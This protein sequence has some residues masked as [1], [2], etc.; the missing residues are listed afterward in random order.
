[1]N[2]TPKET[3]SVPE[4][5]QPELMP[6]EFDINITSYYFVYLRGNHV[7]YEDLMTMKQ[8]FDPVEKNYVIY[9]LSIRNKD[10]NTLNFSINKL[11]L[12]AG[13]QVFAPANPGTTLRY[14]EDFTYVLSEMEKENRLNDTLL[15]PHQN[16]EGI[17]IFQVDNSTTLFDRSFS[18]KYNTTPIPS[19]SYEKSLEALTAAEQFNYSIAFDMPPYDNYLGGDYSFYPEPESNSVWAN[20]VNIS[21]FE[22]Y[23]K[24]DEM[25][26]P[27]EEPGYI[28][29]VEI[30]YAVKVIPEQDLTVF[31][32]GYSIMGG[33]RTSGPWHI[34]GEI[35]GEEK[36]KGTLYVVDDSGE[37]I[38]NK[39]IDS[40]NDNNGLAIL[41]NQT[42]RRFS[43]DMP[44]MMVPHA[45]IV[46]ISFYSTYG[47][48]L[49]MRFTF[50]NQDIVLDEQNN[51][52]LARY[53][54][55]KMVS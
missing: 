27:K 47:W 2:E 22:Y 33:E 50:N 53:D 23:K 49:S 29:N 52:T 32:K 10:T 43:K 18:L 25:S 4:I 42:Y 54:N 41:D 13:V 31:H 34:T 20:W 17:V 55:L 44:Q 5:S 12:H 37:E 11:Q 1:M 24:H 16:L 26:L 15:L 28:P 46:H 21:V 45:T 30:V 36:Y 35:T 48:P 6:A 38:F 9:Q 8:A 14:P 51:I 40:L 7:I 39:S 3:S 19:T